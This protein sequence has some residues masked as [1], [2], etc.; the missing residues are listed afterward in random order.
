MHKR[1]MIVG[2]HVNNIMEQK[3]QKQVP[4]WDGLLTF[5]TIMQILKEWFTLI[6]TPFS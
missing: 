2:K 5:Q 1:T 3:L 6:Q 4:V